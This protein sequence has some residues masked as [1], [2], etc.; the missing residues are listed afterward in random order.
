MIFMAVKSMPIKASADGMRSE[1]E[2]WNRE[3]ERQ[4]QQGREKTMI[5]VCNWKIYG[6]MGREEGRKMNGIWAHTNIPP[7]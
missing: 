3:P 4:K 5:S 1:R 2:R 6:R 7:G